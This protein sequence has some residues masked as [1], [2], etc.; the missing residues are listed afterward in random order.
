M[1][2]RSA[3]SAPSSSSQEEQSSIYLLEGE[4]E[5]KN[6]DALNSAL[7]IIS[8]GKF[9]PLPH[10]IDTQWDALSNRTRN[11]YTTKP[12][13]VVSLAL[14]TTAPLQEECPW[15]AIIQYHRAVKCFE[16]TRPP[17]VA[18]EA[19]LLAYNECENKSTKTQILSVI[20]NKYSQSQI[21]GFLP[22][23]SLRQIKNARRHAEDQGP[24]EP[25]LK[26]QIF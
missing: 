9:K 4:R 17:D 18:L 7:G 6:L 16:N 11:E 22:G 15:Q 24:G 5:W 12:E 2:F 19:I 21:Q 25:V 3:F 23:L 8:Q 1:S 26:E 14:G 20:A 10:Y 13:E